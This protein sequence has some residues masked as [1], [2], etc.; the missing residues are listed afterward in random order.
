MFFSVATYFYNLVILTIK[1]P[2][3]ECI[4][5][6]NDL[7][8]R[9]SIFNYKNTSVHIFI[10]DRLCFYA[11]FL[12]EYQKQIYIVMLIYLKYCFVNIR[13][14]AEKILSPGISNEGNIN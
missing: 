11:G 13:K 3:L 10:R 6:I 1:I 14:F 12:I 7:L 2:I 8:R 5:N 9:V 4:T